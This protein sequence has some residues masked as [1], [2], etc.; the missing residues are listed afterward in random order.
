MT[1]SKIKLILSIH[2]PQNLRIEQVTLSSSS[3]VAPVTKI[4][5]GVEGI[6]ARCL[7]EE[8]A[9]STAAA[10]LKIKPVQ[11]VIFSTFLKTSNEECSTLCQK[12]P[13][14][15]SQFRTIPVTDL[16]TFKWRPLIDE[17]EVKA[18]TLLEILTSIVVFSDH[19]N[20]TKAGSNHHP[21]ICAAV[22]VL[23]KERNCEM[24]GPQSI[25]S[26]LMFF[27]H[28]EKQVLLMTIIHGID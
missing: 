12:S 24:C 19:R 23:L 18:P 7:V 27:C 9:S 16:A 25:V 20:K 2:P 8:H 26:L 10:I 11:E 17:L 1:V 22:G 28:C 6:V 5:S 14:D 15:P 21:S 4:L 3:Q 13:D